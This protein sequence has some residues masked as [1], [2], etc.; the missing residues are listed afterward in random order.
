MGFK[1]K[2]KAVQKDIEKLELSDEVKSAISASFESLDSEFNVY[3]KKVREDHEAVIETEKKSVET[4]S[5]QLDEMKDTKPNFE[6]TDQYKLLKKEMDEFKEKYETESKARAEAEREKE[7]TIIESKLTKGFEE[8]GAMFPELLTKEHID[9]FR[10][11]G[12]KFV[13]GDGDNITDMEKFIETHKETNEKYY[14]A[15]AGGGSE[16]GGKGGQKP[17]DNSIANTVSRAWGSVK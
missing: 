11:S 5:K 10:I 1:D 4:L 9:K 16:T 6:E 2:L 12:D 15:V 17:Q 13:A 8:A 14:G 7:K 3:E